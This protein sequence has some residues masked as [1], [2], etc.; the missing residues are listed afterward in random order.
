MQVVLT[1]LIP[2]A[3]A[4]EVLP[5]NRMYCEP[6]L[7][8]EICR[9]KR[10]APKAYL[11]QSDDDR[12]DVWLPRD[13]GNDRSRE[14][15]SLGDNDECN[16][17]RFKRNK[18]PKTVL[19]AFVHD[20]DYAPDVRE[21]AFHDTQMLYSELFMESDVFDNEKVRNCDIAINYRPG[22]TVHH[23]YWDHGEPNIH[24]RGH[25]GPWSFADLVDQVLRLPPPVLES[26]RKAIA[27]FV[28]N[29]IGERLSYLRTLNDYLPVHNYGS[30]RIGNEASWSRVRI[31]P[32][33]DRVAEK[34]A[35][36]RHYAFGAA[37]ENRRVENYITEKIFE[38]IG[39]NTLTIYY[40]A[41]HARRELYP[42]VPPSSCVW[43]EDF[44]DADELGQY[45]QALA[46]DYKAYRQ[47]FRW[48]NAT[49]PPAAR[50]EQWQC[51]LCAKLHRW[52]R[53]P[54]C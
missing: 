31:S 26:R 5:G 29:C 12:F 38:A 27:S 15:Y 19:A 6:F 40:G 11:P 47:Y 7:D 53:Q 39:G 23:D 18:T 32:N 36:L 54:F 49:A 43:A 21:S 30:C 8:N 17:C 16:H 45:M 9:S 37:F 20:A 10:F 22:A 25:R 42:V 33:L 2:A 28:S 24:L 52:L 41:P 46:G 14:Y 51:A 48:R 4:C 50:R 35:I 44:V 34:A 3:A 1:F 13:R